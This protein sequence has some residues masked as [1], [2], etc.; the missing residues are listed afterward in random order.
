[1]GKTTAISGKRQEMDSE[2]VCP[3][4]RS[5]SRDLLIREPYPA[6]GS[7]PG[8]SF[9]IFPWFFVFSAW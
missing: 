7:S 5:F 6:A 1:M 4:P 3:T 2:L 8:G 9:S